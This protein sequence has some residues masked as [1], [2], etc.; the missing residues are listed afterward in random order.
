MPNPTPHYI[1][2]AVLDPIPLSEPRRILII[3]DLN[4]TLLHRPNKRRPFHFVERPHAKQFLSYCLDTFY[5]AIWSS[6]R[7]ENVDKMVDK[8]LTKEQREKC[9]LIWA[10]DQFGLSSE[11]YNTRV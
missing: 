9:L 10:R 4:G 7:P 2:Q 8:L 1:T 6:A 3:M 5:V 11:D